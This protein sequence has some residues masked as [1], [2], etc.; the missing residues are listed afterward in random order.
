MSTTAATTPATV[1]GVSWS[2]QHDVA[3]TFIQGL[4]NSRVEHFPRFVEHLR[5][6]AFAQRSRIFHRGGTTSEKSSSSLSGPRSTG[7]APTRL[8]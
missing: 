6:V 3:S 8:S 5:V 4:S 2:T 1:V 7:S